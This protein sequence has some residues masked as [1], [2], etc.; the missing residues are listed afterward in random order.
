MK[1][2]EPNNAETGLCYTKK[3][4]Q[5]EKTNQKNR[6]TN[7]KIAEN[8]S[9][10]LLCYCFLFGESVF[11]SVCVFAWIFTFS[12]PVDLHKNSA[13]NQGVVHWYTS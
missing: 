7:K 3:M 12:V 5:T 2:Y 1:M 4:E 8:P 6:K 9:C 13:P 11:D 10:Y